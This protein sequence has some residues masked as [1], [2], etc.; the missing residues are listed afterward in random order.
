VL[1]LLT[2]QKNDLFRLIQNHKFSPSEFSWGEVT[3]SDFRTSPALLYGSTD[4][5]FI[6]DDMTHSYGERGFSVRCTPGQEYTSD[7]C[8]LGSWVGVVKSF[9]EWLANVRRETEVPD[10]WEGLTNE[11]QIIQDA[12]EQPSNNLPFTD[13]ELSRVQ[14]ALDDV[15]TYILKTHELSETQTKRIE[16]RFDYLEEKAASFG[17]KDWLN[18]VIGVLLTIG[19]EQLRNGDSTRDLFLFAGEVFRKCLGTVLYLA[20]PH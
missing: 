19:L 4:F 14:K 17:R 7:Y 11:R 8:E 15:K 1:T 16:A 10:L 9:A 18:L 12:D 2:S 3:S 20:G 13:E 5:Q 6:I